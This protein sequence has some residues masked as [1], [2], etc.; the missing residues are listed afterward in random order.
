MTSRIALTSA[1]VVLGIFL[2]ACAKTVIDQS[3][4]TD[5]NSATLPAP[6][7]GKD[8]GA[9]SADDS[10]PDASSKKTTPPQDNP[11]AT[12]GGDCSS[13]TSRDNCIQCCST[14]HQTGSDTFYG[15]LI[16]CLCTT[17]C[18]SEC[19]ASLCDQNNPTQPDATCN[20]CIQSNGSSCQNDVSTACSADPDCVAFNQCLQTSACNTKP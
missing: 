10:A 12:G 6:S 4:T 13:E 7:K 11:P 8:A 2:F 15:T 20:A 5:G 19:S 1:T 18:V 3:P 16:Q 17:A 14:A 9:T